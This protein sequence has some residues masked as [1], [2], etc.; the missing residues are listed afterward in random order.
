MSKLRPIEL[1]EC[2]RD[3][4]QGVVEFIPTSVKKEYYQLLLQVGFDVIDIGSFVSP[5]A[6]PQMQD[7]LEV[8]QGLDLSSTASKLLTIVANE[9]GVHEAAKLDSVTYLGY[10][11]SISP[12]FQYNNTRQTIEESIL[13]VEKTMGVLSD[14]KQLVVYLSMGF[15]NPYNEPYSQEIV[16]SYIEL[17]RKIGVKIIS[18]ADTVGKATPEF[19]YTI[20]NGIEA[21][22]P[23]VTIG[24]HLHSKRDEAKEKMKVVLESGIRRMDSALT[25]MGGCPFA[26]D[27]L[28]GNIPTE[29]LVELLKEKSV[30]LSLNWGKYQEALQMAEW[31]KSRYH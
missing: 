28:V 31:I 20:L 2:P 6:V 22:Y 29:I 9:R 21:R 4:F 10:P 24:V 16:E 1:V 17:L 14:S 25:G 19:L 11:L 18:I 12:T 27:D 13:L 7:T 3:A 23:D 5:K 15:G 8:L 26:Q 30:H